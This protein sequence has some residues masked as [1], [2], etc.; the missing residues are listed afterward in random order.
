MQRPA[1]KPDTSRSTPR[2]AGSAPRRRGAEL[3]FALLEAAVAELTEHGYD[4]FS[5]DG[6]AGRAGTNKNTLY[7]RWPSRT[8]LGVAAFMAMV[9]RPADPPDTGDLRTDVLTLLRQV[10]D[11]IGDPATGR[12]LAALLAEAR[13]QP[14]LMADLRGQLSADPEVM[15]G[16]LAAAVARGQARPESLHRRIYRL[17]ITLLQAEYLTAGQGPI[18]D[19]TLIEIVD[20]IFL[21]LVTTGSSPVSDQE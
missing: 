4:G 19:E 16:I 20:L 11:R 18:P 10:A 17:P 9:G 21:P 13:R 8:A 3:E 7:R 6:V 2:R 5:M 14:D 15:L 1:P 12:I